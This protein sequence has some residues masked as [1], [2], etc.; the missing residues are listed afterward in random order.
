MKMYETWMMRIMP[1]TDEVEAV[2]VVRNVAH[3]VLD[4]FDHEEDPIILSNVET[5]ECFSVGELRR[6]LTI[7]SCLG[8]DYAWEIE[9]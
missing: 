1:N 9:I 3:M 7:I 5:G 8:K 4:K 2:E 6:A